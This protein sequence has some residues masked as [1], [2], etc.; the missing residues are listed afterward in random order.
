[1]NV[2]NSKVS[3][4]QGARGKEQGVRGKAQGARGTGQGARDKGQSF[5]E[6]SMIDTASSAD[7]RDVGFHST[8][9]RAELSP[10]ADSIQDLCLSAVLQ[11]PFAPAS[12]KSE[13]WLLA[14][15][16][17]KTKWEV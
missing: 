8:S 11:L 3:K 13:L 6:Q 10:K 7:M 4:G 15:S 17:S 1:M 12:G 14:V 9:T 5:A 2:C 16:K